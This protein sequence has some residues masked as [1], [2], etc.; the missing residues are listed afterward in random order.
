MKSVWKGKPIAAEADAHGLEARLAHGITLGQNEAQLVASIHTNYKKDIHERA[1]AHHAKAAQVLDH[2]GRKEPADR[3]RGLFQMHLAEA[4]YDPKHG[5]PPAV[6]VHLVGS[7]DRLSS[8]VPHVAD[9]L[10]GAKR[11]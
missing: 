11:G 5:V 9:Q 1:A 2:A 6:R 7:A 8:F 10:L 4:G 3:H